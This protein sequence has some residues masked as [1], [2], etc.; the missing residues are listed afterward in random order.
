MKFTRSILMTF[1]LF[2]TIIYMSCNQEGA[3]FSLP[4][5]DADAGKMVFTEL[6]CSQCHS[7]ADITW[8]GEGDAFHVELGGE[9]SRIKSY[10]ELVTSV[11]NP[12]HKLAPEFRRQM[13]ANRS[14]QSPM[15]NYNSLMTVQELVDLVTYLQDQYEVIPPETHYNNW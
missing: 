7:V 1:T 8:E 4:P 9:V 13:E 15:P 3:G 6:G 2:T 14:D 10:G 5:G 11:I 12:S